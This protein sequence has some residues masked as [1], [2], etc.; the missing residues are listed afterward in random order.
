MVPQELAVDGW[1][2]HA[3]TPNLDAPGRLTY[4][5]WEMP[6]LQLEAT[7]V[8]QPSIRGIRGGL[9]DM[10][11]PDDIVR[12]FH[13]ITIHG[14]TSMG[15]AL[16]LFGAYPQGPQQYRAKHAIFG[17]HLEEN[18][19]FAAV[20]YQIDND[21]LWSNIAET[22]VSG[23]L[24]SLTCQRDS[25]GTWFVFVP[26]EPMSLRDL[27][28]RVLIAS[29]TLARLALQRELVLG[30]AFVQDAEGSAWLPWH[31]TATSGER[32]DRYLGDWL[33]HP[34]AISLQ[35]LVN[36]LGVS[37]TLDGLDA[38]IADDRLA[39]ILELRALVLGTIAEGLHRRLFDEKARFPAL[40]KAQAKGVRRAGREAIAQALDDLGVTAF[41][42][43]FTDLVA[44]LN[45]MTARQRLADIKAAVDE[46][47]PGLLEE[48]DDWPGLV[49][50]TRDY[51]AHWL[52][53][54][55]DDDYVPPS[56]DD[57]MLVYMSLPW[58]LRTL[59]LYRAA[60]LDS[61]LMRQGY[62][63]KPEYEMFRANVRA[64]AHPSG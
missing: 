2:W 19:R 27:G 44:A 17:A 11:D 58:V 37:A 42:G 21:V 36:W 47:I 45:R 34:G 51:L 30:P 31:T 61:N 25:G 43:D 57:K 33:V 55:D 64:I 38:A 59:L 32:I 4:P 35:H 5:S 14:T 15:E 56:E 62:A 16:T 8:E 18:Q 39:D 22:T 49:K 50:D 24:G 20:R 3:E 23:D 53:D 1:F 7:I 41:P 40:T 6:V 9:I 29:R 28:R 52:L 26:S 46:V 12:D 63:E 60:K 10:G 13:P 54:D 48:F